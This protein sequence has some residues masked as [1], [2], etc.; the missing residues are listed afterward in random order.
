MVS[1]HRVLLVV[2]VLVLAELSD[3]I[4]ERACVFLLVVFDVELALLVVVA[5]EVRALHHGHPI[6]AV[7][8]GRSAGTEPPWPRSGSLG[9]F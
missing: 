3:R 9:F 1:V 7:P 2:L 4:R 5:I 6:G 8:Y